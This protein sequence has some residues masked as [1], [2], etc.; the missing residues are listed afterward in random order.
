MAYLPHDV[1]EAPR[2]R[3]GHA[4]PMQ[5]FPPGRDTL[6]DEAAWGS[7]LKANGPVQRRAVLGSLRT[8]HERWLRYVVR[9]CGADVVGRPG[10]E[11]PVGKAAWIRMGRP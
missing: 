3:G 6:R 10:F 7:L 9:S 4:I 11:P 5:S 8:D 1:E 2:R